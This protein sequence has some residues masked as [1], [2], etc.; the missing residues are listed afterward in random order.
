MSQENVELARRAIEAF[1]AGDWE[2][3][4]EVFDP[5]VIIPRAVERAVEDWPEPAPFVGREAVMRQWQRSAE[6]WDAYKLEPISIID[7][8]DR[9]VARLIAHAIGRG[10]EVHAEFTTVCT[11]RNSK[12]FLIEYFRDHVQALE[13]AGLSEQDAHADS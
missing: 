12:V 7:A 9:V 11:V 2:V 10:P 3:V 13:A 4:R 8:G 1:N 6:P 5:D